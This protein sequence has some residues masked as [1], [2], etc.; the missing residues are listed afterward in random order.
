[1]DVPAMGE[2]VTEQWR[3]VEHADPSATAG[4][5]GALF[6]QLETLL[7]ERFPGG[8][9]RVLTLSLD[10]LRP[11]PANATISV[12]IVDRAVGRRTV[13]LKVHLMGEG[14]MTVAVGFVRV[15]LPKAP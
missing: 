1:M 4:T 8:G 13:R 11:L 3:L 6:S 7:Q 10:F 9:S 12:T 5:L 15:L 2:T 14:A